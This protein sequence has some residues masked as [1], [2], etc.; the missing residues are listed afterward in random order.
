[1]ESPNLANVHGRLAALVDTG[2]LCA[3]YPFP[4]PLLADVCFE[5]GDRCEHPEQ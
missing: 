2:N 5:L 4:L 1:M 3:V